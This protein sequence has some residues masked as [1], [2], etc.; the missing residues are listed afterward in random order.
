MTILGNTCYDIWGEGEVPEVDVLVA[1]FPG[2]GLIGGIASEQI[3]NS[4]GL[5]QVASLKCND[6]PPTA[7]IFEGVPRRPVRF[8]AGRG[9][10]LVKSDMVIPPEL[11]ES[12]AEA[13]IDEAIEK[14]IKEVI[15]FDGIPER[16]DS[17]EENKIWGVLSSHT[18]VDKAEKLDLD[19]IRRGAISGIS[20][21]LL[22]IAHE[23]N[24]EAI[25]MLAE[26][27][28]NL[29]DPRAAA[30]LLEKFSDYMDIDIEIDTLLES[31]EQLEEQYSQLIE[32]AQEA[33]R[34]MESK[35]AQPPPLYG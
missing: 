23:K 30:K 22:L 35:T 3:I 13:I 17:E 8:F 24:L 1:G 25:G 34:D 12:L 5:E 18:A 16:P 6:F 28:S 14:G 31:A 4:L 7:V 21:S 2:N 26:G 9:F 29:P 32:K 15:I 10:L 33:Q 11:S 27:S 20:S 19:I